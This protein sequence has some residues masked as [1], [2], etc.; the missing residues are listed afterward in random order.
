MRYPRLTMSIVLACALQ[1]LPVFAIERSDAKMATGLMQKAQ[2]YL[3]KNGAEKAIIE[4]NRLDSP[5]NSKS[6]INPYG[7]LYLYTLDSKGFQSVHGKNPKI[8]GKV[9]LEMRDI[10]GVYLIEAMVKICF[11]SKEGKGWT[12]Y[13]W[14]NPVT[15]E[16]EP[17][18]G[19]VERVP[20]MDLCLGTGI[21]Q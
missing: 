8:R 14:P 6:T 5:F 20:G 11:S 19:Y 21:Y 7:D 1:A 4:F 15:K 9:M 2:A 18:Q 16:V 13:R 17:K 12:K 10:D 3:Q